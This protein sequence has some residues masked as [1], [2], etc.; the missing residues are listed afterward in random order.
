MMNGGFSVQ[1][2]SENP[3][4]KLSADQVIEETVNKDTQTS[5]GTNGQMALV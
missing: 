3:F 1:L 4:G 5:G 2:G